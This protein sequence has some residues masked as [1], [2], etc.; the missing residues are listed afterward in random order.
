MKGWN[1][2]VDGEERSRT[3]PEE[4]IENF[5]ELVIIRCKRSDLDPK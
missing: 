3:V 2:E 4:N 1:R 5:E